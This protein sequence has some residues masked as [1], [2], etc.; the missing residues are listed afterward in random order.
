L[1]VVRRALDFSGDRPL[2]KAR[3][4]EL[5]VDEWS[6][7]CGIELAVDLYEPRGEYLSLAGILGATLSLPAAIAGVYEPLY[8]LALS[9]AVA[10]PG[11]GFKLAY[12][13][14][15]EEARS[16]LETLI[17]SVEGS[18]EAAGGATASG[19][20]RH[21]GEGPRSGRGLAFTLL[22]RPRAGEARGG[23]ET[24]SPPADRAWRAS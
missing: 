20:E 11:L 9:P 2:L 8:L 4:V 24:E 15:R 19:R 17:E 12:G 1:G 16:T 6:G 5:V 10:A 23:N 18:G 3:C 22:G 21:R 7:G 13:N 14:A